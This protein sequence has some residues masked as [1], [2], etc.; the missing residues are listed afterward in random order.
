MV[1]LE[2]RFK[3]FEEFIPKIQERRIALYGTGIN[4][5]KIIEKYPQLHIVGLLEEKVSQPYLQGKKNLR[6]EDLVTLK[7]D[8]VIVASQIKNLKVIYNRICTFC[9]ANDIAIYDMYGDD[10]YE[11]FFK[12]EEHQCKLCERNAETLIQEIAKYDIVSIDLFQTLCN[13]NAGFK[14][15]IWW[16][17]AQEYA[18]FI[19]SPMEFA[20]AREQAETKIA[21]REINN[22]LRDVY[23]EVGA[24]L[25]LTDEQV[26]MLLEKE[27]QYIIQSIIV[28]DKMIEILNQAH[29][30]GKRVWAISDLYFSEKEVWDILEKNNIDVFDKVI[31]SKELGC[32][33]H[34]GLFRVLDGENKRWLHIGEDEIEDGLS[35]LIY[36]VDIFLIR[37]ASVLREDTTY[38]GIFRQIQKWYEDG[39][40][41]EIIKYGSNSLYESI[42]RLELL[43]P[44]CYCQEENED[45]S[46]RQQIRRLKK[47]EFPVPEKPKVSIIIPA[48]N[49]FLFTYN[50]L[51]SIL[52]NTKGI[53]YEVIIADDCSTDLT[54]FISEV[55]SGIKVV[56]NKENLRFLRNCNYAAKQASGKYILFL[57]ND[58]YVQP[59]W[60]KELVVLIEK[61]EKIGMVGSKLIYPDGRLQEA[62]GI[63]WR[64]ASAWNFGY[65]QVSGAPVYNYVKETDYISGAAIMIRS[66]LWKEIGGF[67]EQFAPAY[68]EDTDL[69][70]EVRKHGYLVVYNPFS[71]VVHYEGVSNGT[72]VMS[73]QKAYQAANKE[74]FF[75]KWKY[76]LK[77]DHFKNGENVFVAKDRSRYKKHI[78]VVDHYVPQHDHDAGGRCTYMYIKAFLRMGMQVT[79]IGDNFAYSVPYTEELLKMGVEILYGSYYK[80]HIEE[81]LQH[82]LQY[83]DVI[84]LQR[85]HISIKYIDQAKRYSNAKIFY[86]AHDLHHIRLQRQYELTGDEDALIEAKKWKPIEMELF[87]K[88]D[89]GHVVGDFEQKYMQ[90]IYPDKPVRNIPLYIFEDVYK[91]NVLSFQERKDI[92]YVGGFGH[93]PNI[94]AVMWFASEIFPII[95]DK[96]PDIKWHVVGNKPTEEINNLASENIII[97]G[98]VSDE[99]LEELYNT[100]RLAVVP[101]RVG[102]GVK[103]KIVEA[104]YYQVPVV[105]TDVGAEGISSAEKALI[106]ENDAVKMAETIC[107]LYEDYDMLA[108]YA[109]REKQLIENHYLLK[110]AMD[111]L[112]K[113][114]QT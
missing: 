48:Y 21:R 45:I 72:D 26:K 18:S 37:K 33:K 63:V 60:L 59:G 51:F 57:N 103:G 89:V 73:G 61:N 67:D 2:F 74:K 24:I 9:H 28:D 113:D 87:E 31:S 66:E 34:T 56:R 65:G 92:L 44:F 75:E 83:F 69:A 8:A 93:P 111:V 81:W 12:L 52:Q 84:Y 110:N 13:T 82:N 54:R 1:E 80:M 36:G 16:R 5:R 55:I 112:A 43:D 98:F 108:E 11:L 58:T 105:T 47:L 102:A 95:V 32:M 7:V 22:Q 3:K 53:S 17:I 104:A 23:D 97:E 35:P 88:A 40:V 64:D 41:N 107:S 79:F 91:K 114:M 15:R 50:C 68:Y 14:E 109:E 46:E 71:L 42:V 4:A 10:L 100:C 29:K 94:D 78:L 77:K 25:E 101:L 70:F 30:E 106:V 76:T 85:P 99:K 6:I 20:K 49:Q 62:G 39:K 90:K 27:K 96:Y 38:Y 86:F 19:L